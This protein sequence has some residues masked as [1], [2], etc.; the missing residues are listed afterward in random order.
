VRSF[1]FLAVSTTSSL[2]SSFNIQDTIASVAK[3]RKTDEE[4]R[5]TDEERKKT[6]EERKKTDEERKKMEKERKQR[7]EEG[8]DSY[9]GIDSVPV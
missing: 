7:E 1:G 5:K 9:D 2:I 8:D 3:R 4:R 6:D